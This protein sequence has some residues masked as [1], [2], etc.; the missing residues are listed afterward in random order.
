MTKINISIPKPCHENWEGMT[1]EDKGRFCNSCQKKV[2]DFTKSSDR[3]IVTAFQQNENLCGRFMETQLNRDLIKPER[4]NSIW[5]AASSAIISFLG[6]GTHEATAQ[7]EPIKTEQT[8][9]KI[10]G[11][12]AAPIKQG[13]VATNPEIEVSGI[14]SDKSGQLPGA[15]VSVKGTDVHVQTDF[16]GVFTIKAKIDDVIV[17]TYVGYDNFEFKASQSNKQ[18]KIVL[19][20]ATSKDKELIYLGYVVPSKKK[21]KN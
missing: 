5:M 17:V 18:K 10:V 11:K 12:P 16:D 13:E 1:P 20:E 8:D 7:G 3:E 19:K 4:K 21:K 6:L 14:V 15:T 2:F 9:R